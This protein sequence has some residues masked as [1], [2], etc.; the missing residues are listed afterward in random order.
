[1]VVGK[2]A[3]L[4]L[5]Q[6]PRLAV[7]IAGKLK[8]LLGPKMY[9]KMGGLR[10]LQQVGQEGL[11]SG[12]FSGGMTAAG[13][14]MSGEGLDIPEILAYGLADTVTGGLAVGG[15]RAL[16]GTKGFKKAT[17]RDKSGNTKEVIT[18]PKEL[19]R[20]RGELPA[21]VLASA[22][23]PMAVSSA[24]GEKQQPQ[25]SAQ[26]EQ[27]D[28]QQIQRMLLNEGLLAGQYLPGTMFQGMGVQPPQTLMQQY[29]ND[30]GPQIS[31]DPRAMASIV[32]L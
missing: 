23:T 29:L 22:L 5:N 13:Q 17:V 10:G 20:S 1:M 19:I 11:Y 15:V 30:Q 3:A 16:R 6:A 9:A 31:M 2:V 14:L 32:G 26:T 25:Q 27:V 4:T 7:N 8:G 18:T 21:N 28:Q 12:L 24:L